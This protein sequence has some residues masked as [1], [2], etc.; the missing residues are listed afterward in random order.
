VLSQTIETFINGE[1]MSMAFANYS[2]G[3][4]GMCWLQVPVDDNYGLFEV[5]SQ[6]D[7]ECAIPD[8][9]PFSIPHLR[10]NSRLIAKV[11]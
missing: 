3:Q 9:A 4:S 2:T 7:L 11:L 6:R 10:I 1:R 5:W 8:L